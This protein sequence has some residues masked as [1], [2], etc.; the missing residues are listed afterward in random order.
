MRP[1][2]EAIEFETALINSDLSRIELELIDYIR[3]AGT[4]TQP[5]ARRVLGL[6]PKPPVLSLICVA[7]RKIGHQIPKHFQKVRDWSIEI[8]DD[9][10]RWDGSL[11]CSPT[12][13]IDGIKLCPENKNCQFHTF[14]VHTE[15]FNGL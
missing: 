11:I 13:N 14:A 9:G 1:I 3:F 10:I 4:F 8:S 5:S 7:C 15:L 2:L 12:F 6:D